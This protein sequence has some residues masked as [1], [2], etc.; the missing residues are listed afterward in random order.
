M[1]NGKVGQWIQVGANVGILAGLVLVGIQI[2][3]NSELV[4][5]QLDHETW[6]DNL[7]LHLAMMGDNPSAAVAKAMENPSD[8]T[9][10]E[11]RILD[12]Y[13]SYWAL[14]RLREIALYERGMLVVPPP[15]YASDDPASPLHRRIL[16]NAYFKARYEDGLGPHLTPRLKQLMDSLSGDEALKE[17]EN[18]IRRITGS[19]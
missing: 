1:M 2:N 19:R 5:E 13:L 16:G 18:N 17:Y 6:T 7:N 8:I 15:T 11:S 9:V 14:S 3:Q 10:E 4:R 12:A